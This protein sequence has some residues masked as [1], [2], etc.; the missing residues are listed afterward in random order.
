MELVEVS[1][2]AWRRGVALRAVRSEGRT[3]D[4][5][6]AVQGGMC[7]EFSIMDSS[8]QDDKGGVHARP[9]VLKY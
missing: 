1:H 4:L 9:C 8:E 5:V 2:G 3:S 7:T 6:T